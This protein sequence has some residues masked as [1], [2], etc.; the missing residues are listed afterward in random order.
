MDNFIPAKK[1]CK[2]IFDGTHETPKPAEQGYPLV[3]SKNILGGTLDLTNTY[4][5]SEKDYIE[6]QKRSKVSKWDILFSMIG[7]VGEI[8]L[9]KNKTIPYAIK[10]VGVFSC[11]KEYHAK[12]LYYYLKSPYAKKFIRNYLSGAVQKFLPLE[13]LRNFP[14]IPYDDKYSKSIDLLSCIESKIE[15][16]IK[17]NIELESFIKTLYKYWF[18]QFDFP[19]AN[20]KPYKTSGNKMIWNDRFKSEIPATWH[21]GTFKDIIDKIECGDRP[22]GGIIKID[23]GVPSI[24][25]EN[26]LGIGKYN[27]DQEKLISN[28]YFSKMTKGI[29]KSGDVLMY[30]DGAGLGQVS[31]FKN[32]FPYDKCCINSHVFILRSNDKIS[33]NYLY[34]WLDQDY[35]KKLI[36]RLGMKAA[37]P[38]INQED[39]DQIPIIIPDKNL[40][41]DFEN[42]ISSSIDMIFANSKL[43]KIL[44]ELMNWLLPLQINEQVKV[45]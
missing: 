2:I 10:N 6:I 13:T 39:V 35:I 15:T 5:I 33:Q 38:G 3:T 16:N 19:D 14:V 45:N 17:I 27:F 43:N 36:V 22:E 20:G 1:Y 42:I 29:V 21:V 26:I 25:A 31:I 40:I 18:V 34:F 4:Y 30:K 7:S 37:Q 9:E 24:G 44:S 23:K 41:I 32:A 28:D 11:K 8:Y 12:W